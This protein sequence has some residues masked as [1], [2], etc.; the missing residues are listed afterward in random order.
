[1]LTPE[2]SASPQNGDLL[3]C[4]SLSP[5]LESDHYSPNNQKYYNEHLTKVQ[6][7]SILINCTLRLLKLCYSQEC[8]FEDAKLKYFILEVMRR[9]KT[10]TQSLQIC[11]YYLFKIINGKK[12]VDLCPKKLFLGMIILASKFN[13]D[14]NYSAKTWLKICGCDESTENS[15]LNL[16]K[17]KETERLCLQTLNY[18]LYINSA[19]YENWCNVLLIFGYD[20]IL[21]HQVPLGILNWYGEGACVKKLCYWK[22]FLIRLEESTLKQTRINFKQYYANQ[23][24]TKVVTT[25]PS[26]IG[27]VLGKRVFEGEPTA[28]K[29]ACH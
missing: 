3:P 16:A 12:P 9:S 26:K 5:T 1:M 24:G 19:K 8:R 29:R 22:M 27:S 2:G 20:F 10:T 11:C 25:G 28:P 13:Q 21:M 6:F 23:I 14:H 7:N 18:S 15:T 4:T 17:L